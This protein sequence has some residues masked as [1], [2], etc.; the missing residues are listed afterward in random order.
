MIQIILLLFKMTLPATSE[1]E[2]SKKAPKKAS[3]KRMRDPDSAKK[4]ESL[5]ERLEGFYDKLAMWQLTGTL[6]NIPS[7]STTKEWTQAFY[8][9]VIDPLCDIPHV[10]IL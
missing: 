6:E 2:V 10:S 4:T 9:D 3:R 7:A 5:E 1:V 8:E